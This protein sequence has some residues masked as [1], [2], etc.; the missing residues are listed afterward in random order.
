MTRLYE[1]AKRIFQHHD[2]T[3]LA[4][5]SGVMIDQQ[6]IIERAVVVQARQSGIAD[7]SGW[8]L[9]DTDDEHFCIS[10]LSLA[11]VLV[12]AAQLVAHSY[13]FAVIEEITAE[14]Q[15]LV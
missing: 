4:N 11:Y 2:V 8:K 12:E 13:A 15:G 7:M 6:F 14:G 9:T 10:S 3:S 5:N 1:A